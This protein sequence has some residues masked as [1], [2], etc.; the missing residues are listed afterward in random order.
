MSLTPLATDQA[1][2]VSIGTPAE[3]ARHLVLALV[4]LGQLE[5]DLQRL[6]RALA[7]AGVS[8][9]PRSGLRVVRWRRVRRASGGYPTL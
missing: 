6:S 2:S 4:A 7:P 9:Q 8:A 1:T 3:R 5:R